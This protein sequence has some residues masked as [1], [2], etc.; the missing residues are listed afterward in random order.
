MADSERREAT[1]NTKQ[2]DEF[3]AVLAHELRNPLSP[4]SSAVQ[5]LHLKGSESEEGQWALSVIDRQMLH[6]T[7]LIDDL[8]DVAR[9]T[10][11]KL[12]L[13]KEKIDLRDVLQAALETSG[14][15][16]KDAGHDF[17]TTLPQQPVYLNG[18]IVRLAQALANLLSN[19]A[20]YT[21]RGGRIWLTAERSKTEAII[22]IRDTGIGISP[23]MLPHI[24]DMFTQIQRLPGSGNGLG[25]GLTLV[26]RLLEMHDGAVHIESE[27]EGKG[28]VCTVRLPLVEDDFLRPVTTTLQ[29]EHSIS[30][31]LRVLIVDDNLDAAATMDIMLSLLGHETFVGHDGLEAIEKAKA[32]LPDVVLLDIGMPNMNGYEAAKVIRSHEWGQKMTL[33]AL[34]GWGQE[35]DKDES[36]TAGFD[37]HLTKPVDVSELTALLSTVNPRQDT[38]R[39]SLY[40]VESAA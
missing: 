4:I 6:M 29:E 5:I 13:R 9:L 39:I 14:P 23:E 34:T 31:Q 19:A 15:H 38:A 32:H 10:G 21:P 33:I 24:F 37:H 1:V 8:L 22:T 17:V 28:S 20:K 7:R 12:E 25:I 16:I 36:R 3:L 40:R 2:T 11:N 30:A 26:K 18:D 27:G 35:S